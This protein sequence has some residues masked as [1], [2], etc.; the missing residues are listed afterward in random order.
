ML[1]SEES[2]VECLLMTKIVGECNYEM[3][4]NVNKSHQISFL[5]FLNFMA[6]PVAY[7][8]LWARD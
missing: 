1:N 2:N 7:G 6:A 4:G 3:D 8:S 5:N